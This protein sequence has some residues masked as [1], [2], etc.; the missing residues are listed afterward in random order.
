MTLYIRAP[1]GPDG[2]VVEQGKMELVEGR[3]DATEMVFG[4]ADF[5]EGKAY[6]KRPDLKWQKEKLDN[7]KFVVRGD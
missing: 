1:L 2:I 7:K 5:L 4:D 3:G 6:E